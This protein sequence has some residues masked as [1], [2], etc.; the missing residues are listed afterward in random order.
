MAK[1]QYFMTTIPDSDK[2]FQVAIINSVKTHDIG[3]DVNFD[4]DWSPFV[5]NDAVKI[6]PK[7]GEKI[8][9]YGKGLGYPVRGIVIGGRVYKYLT[10]AEQEA[11][12]AAERERIRVEREAA[13]AAFQAAPKPPLDEFRVRDKAAFENFVQINS[14]DG[15]SYA[16]VQY[17]ARW[18]RLMEENIAKG[19]TG[20][21]MVE[22]T[23]HEANTDGITG[24]MHGAARAVLKHHWAEDIL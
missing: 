20:K 13:D 15:Y 11:A 18:A 24:A 4:A 9:L 6:A 22:R 14:Q 7:P 21:E 17:A 16:C 12:N 8:E 19:V 1:G 3:F 23:S 10:A 5:P 2:P